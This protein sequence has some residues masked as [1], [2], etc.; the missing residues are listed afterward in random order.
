MLLGRREF[1][2]ATAAGAVHALSPNEKLRVA[3]IGVGGMRGGAHLGGVG[4]EA[5]VALCDVDE[6]NLGKAAA[7]FPSA[8]KY[9]DFRVM[10]EK[11]GGLD[12]VVVSTPDHVHAPAAAMALRLGKH[13]YSEKPLTHTVREART[14]A[15]LTKKHKRVTQLGTQIH[16]GTNY[17]RVVELIRSGGI[18]KVSDGHVWVG[19]AWWADKLPERYPPVPDWIHWD[20]WIGPSAPRPYHREYHPTNWRKWWNFGGGHLADMGCHYIDLPF[21][22][23]GL[24]H[25]TSVEA[26]GP[27]PHAEGAPKHLTVTW[28][29]PETRLTWYHGGKR[30]PHFDEGKMEGWKGNGVLFVGEKGMLVSGYGNHKLLPGDRFADFKRPEPT[31]ANSIGHHKEWLEACKTGGTTTCNFD[32]SGALT[33]TVLLGNVAFRTGEKLTWDAATLKTSSKKADALLHKEYRKGWT[34]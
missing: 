16:A 29:F 31:I 20:L 9:V 34:L 26:K 15:E 12:A 3:V 13:V 11:E 28:E 6:R 4:G 33:E 23:L 19:G 8:K 14:L 22:A 24:R 5:V 32:Y 21:W 18:G 7:R 1:M 2:A 10:L 25:P 30:P 17:R 27:E